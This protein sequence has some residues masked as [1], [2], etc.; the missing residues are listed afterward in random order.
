MA[1]ILQKGIPVRDKV[2]KYLGYQKGRQQAVEE[3]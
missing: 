1:L 3:I 2:R